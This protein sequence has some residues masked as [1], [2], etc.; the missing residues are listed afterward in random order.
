M[1]DQFNDFFSAFECEVPSS[2]YSE[3]ESRK[4]LL[5]QISNAEN[6]SLAVFDMFKKEDS[7]VRSKFDQ[8]LSYS[9][10]DLYTKEPGEFF[11]LMPESDVAFS[12]DTI[13]QAFAF[14]REVEK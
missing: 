14:F 7:L 11:G 9:F 10:N 5:L 12:F 2:A 8:Q 1:I 6:S 3:F 4:K 13:R